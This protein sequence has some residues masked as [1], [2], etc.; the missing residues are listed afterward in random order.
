MLCLIV[1]ACQQQQTASTSLLNYLPNNAL[2]VVKSESF[3]SMQTHANAHVA[4]TAIANVF[5][6]FFSQ[7]DA[8]AEN[9]SGQLSF[10]PEGKDKLSY[11]WITHQ[12]PPRID[13]IVADT[14]TYAKTQLLQLNT[15]PPT[16]YATW[17]WLAN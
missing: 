7:L 3:A 14:L 6:S 12:K 9:T 10:H 5:P 11:L 13:S 4:A 1:G 17:D 2:V 16:Y 15:S 8:V